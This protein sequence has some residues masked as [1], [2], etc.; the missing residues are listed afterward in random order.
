MK[1]LLALLLAALVLVSVPVT[2][3][4]Q[5]PRQVDPSTAPADPA[6]G[7]GLYLFYGSIVAALSGGN[8]TAAKALIGQTSFIHIPPEILDAVNSFNGL[9]NSTANLFTVIDSQLINAS[10][11]ISTG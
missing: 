4:I 5:F 9:V 10:G 1:K 2:L 7:Q 11:Y 8:F 3:A 6:Y